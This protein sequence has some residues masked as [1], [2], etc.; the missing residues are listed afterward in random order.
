MACSMSQLMAGR[1]RESCVWEYF[2][3]SADVDKSRCLVVDN[4]TGKQCGI[5]LAG[6]NTSNGI[7]HL[8]RHHKK[9]HAAFELAEKKKAAAKCGL[10]RTYEFSSPASKVQTL[11]NCFQRKSITWPT[12]SS[13]HR[14]RV[15]GV[16]DMVIC[17]R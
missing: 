8:A 7:N 4:K 15:K 10:K 14:L 16:L 9:E 6:K 2:E 11:R 17:R 5:Q 3:Y 12:D 13:E 1:K